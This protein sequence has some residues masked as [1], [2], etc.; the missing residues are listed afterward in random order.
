MRT[1]IQVATLLSCF[2]V[3]S[4][5]DGKDRTYRIIFPDRPGNAPKSAFLFDGTTSRKVLLPSMN[6]SEVLKLPA[7][8][9]ELG[10][11]ANPVSSSYELPER[12]P[13]VTIPES[14]NDF[15]LIVLSDPENPVLPVRI[16]PVEADGFQLVAGRMLWINL[17]KH[18]VKGT[19]GDQPIFLP[20]GSS[21]LG[22]APLPASGY[23]KAS[24]TYQPEPGSEFVP[25]MEKSWWHDSKSSG[26][27]FIVD[28]GGRLPRIFTFR[29]HRPREESNPE[30]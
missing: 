23:Y 26:L 29:D 20:V 21:V 30:D 16:L 18:T 28:S 6:F 1:L 27:A 22:E 10:L 5:G 9:L 8:E 24:F 19:L 3:V 4:K 15:H 13:S 7:G 25:M 2:T 17:S 12:T 11:T 14:V